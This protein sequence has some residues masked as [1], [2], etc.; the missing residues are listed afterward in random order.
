MS[1]NILHIIPTNLFSFSIPL[2][3]SWPQSTGRYLCPSDLQ[4]SILN[5]SRGNT[6]SHLLLHLASY[7]HIYIYLCTNK[8]NRQLVNALKHRPKRTCL[9]ILNNTWTEFFEMTR[10]KWIIYSIYFS[11]QKTQNVWCLL[12]H[13]IVP[14]Y[15]LVNTSDKSCQASQ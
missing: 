4:H 1:S 10:L 5:P 13:Q 11:Q 7:M 15:C 2:S 6:S 3:T 8:F 9:F 14:S 12:K